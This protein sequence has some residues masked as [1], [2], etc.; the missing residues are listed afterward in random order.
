MMVIAYMERNKTIRHYDG[1]DRRGAGVGLES[2]WDLVGLHHHDGRS[3]GREIQ[4]HP[5]L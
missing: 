5:S 4:D 2:G 1:E 3:A